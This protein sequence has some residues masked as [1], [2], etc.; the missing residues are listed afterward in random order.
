MFEVRSINLIR[1]KGPESRS[2]YKGSSENPLC[3]IVNFHAK[4]TNFTLIYLRMV[5]TYHCARLEPSDFWE[6]SPKFFSTRVGGMVQ[7]FGAEGPLRC[8]STR[9][10]RAVYEKFHLK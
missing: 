1:Y 6:S 5:Y 8:G 7:L 4:M 2:I 3:E 10:R 9:Q